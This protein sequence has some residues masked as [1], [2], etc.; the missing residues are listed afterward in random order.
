MSPIHVAD[1]SVCN[2]LA[3]RKSRC[4]RRQAVN[5]LEADE[6]ATGERRTALAAYVAGLEGQ[7]TELQATELRRLLHEQTDNCDPS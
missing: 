4:N 5:Q 7:A 2:R 3:A 6:Q 1:R